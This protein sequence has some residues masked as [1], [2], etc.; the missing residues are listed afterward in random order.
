MS[1]LHHSRAC[2][3]C[4]R[5]KTR[6]NREMPCNNCLKSRK[7]EACVYEDEKSVL[8]RTL[9]SSRHNNGA[10]VSLISPQD[11]SGLATPLAQRPKSPP[12]SQQEVVSTPASDIE[13]RTSQIGGTFHIHHPVADPTLSRR[14][15][16]ALPS[17]S[18][19]HQ[20]V[21]T[22]IRD[23]QKRLRGMSRNI[24]HKTRL[25]GQSHWFNTLVPLVRMSLSELMFKLQ[26][27][28][29]KLDPFCV[30]ERS[31]T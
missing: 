13:T 9:R 20:P 27:K 10:P 21:S 28:L 14:E 16:S 19:V 31:T 15:P 29:T 3:L 6:C 22:G 26:A 12:T 25:F 4:R 18:Q 7:Q 1:H 23:S 2:N 11:N 24:S 8:P 30:I 17:A 5:R